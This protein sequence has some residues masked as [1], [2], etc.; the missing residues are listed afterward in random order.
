MRFVISARDLSRVRFA[1][2]PLWECVS[3]LFTLQ[4][5]ARGAMHALWLRDQTPLNPEDRAL[6]F[7]LVRISGYMP[8]F[9]TPPPHEP[10][11]S[12]EIEL[13]RLES[14]PKK[15]VQAELLKM[16][17]FERHIPE[18]ARTLFQH[19][20]DVLPRIADVLHT[21]WQRTLE[22]HWAQMR[23]LLE[24]DINERSRV[25]AI[26]GPE[27]MLNNLHPNLICGDGILERVNSTHHTVKLGGRGVLLVPSVFVTPK[28]MGIDGTAYQ[29]TMIY[30]AR[31][32]LTLWGDPR[33][34]HQ[35]EELLGTQTARVFTLLHAPRTTRDLA[36]S[37]S[38]PESGASYHVTRL[39]NAGLLE[40]RRSGRQVFHSRSSRGEALVELFA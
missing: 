31:G 29:P 24:A 28:V 18:A 27:V 5:E 7:S 8:D 1:I 23:A 9:L 38:L 32:A 19:P 35:L 34:S 20:R 3:S 11:P 17:G 30:P 14:T 6:L 26:E 21:H 4:D 37:L 25:L 2:S 22:P 12:L 36:Q 33:P 40:S 13:Q 10:F 15:L 39:R 16:W